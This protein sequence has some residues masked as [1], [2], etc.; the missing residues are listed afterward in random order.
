MFELC[1]VYEA[2]L[3]K[4]W[5]LA[6][7]ELLSTPFPSFSSWLSLLLQT[8]LVDLDEETVRFSGSREFLPLPAPLLT[9]LESE[10]KQ[11]A[12]LGAIK[13][14]ACWSSLIWFD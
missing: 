1:V 12:G 14:C 5:P 8:C 13:V 7:L 4:F 11:Y 3:P 9:R 10:L 6:R 2:Y